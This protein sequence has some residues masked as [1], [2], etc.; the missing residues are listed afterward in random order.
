[1]KFCKNCGEEIRP[2]A[3]VCT[4]C[5]HKVEVAAE[6]VEPVRQPEPREPMDPVKK[7][8]LII[9]AA[10]LTMVAIIIVIVYNLIAGALSPDNKLDTIAEAVTEEDA[11][12][13][14]KSVD[15]D[16]TLEEA[17]AYI[18]YVDEVSGLSKYKSWVG[19]VKTA[20]GDDAPG[21]DIFDG[22]YTLLSVNKDGSQYW[23]FDDYS[24]T[25]PRTNIYI[26]ESY[27]MDKF[28]YTMDET[29]K[30]WTSGS[31]K[32]DELIPGKYQFD[33][34]AEFDDIETKFPSSINID[35]QNSESA[36]LDP[37][38]YYLTINESVTSMYYEDV[39]KDGLTVTVGGEEVEVNTNDSSDRLGPYQF[40]EELDVS[41]TVTHA[42]ETFESTN[43]PLNL[44]YDEVGMD[45]STGEA[46]PVH[47]IELEFDTDAIYEAGEAERNA[48]QLEE[49]REAFEDDME[50]N[51]ESFLSDYLYALETMYMFEDIDHIEDYVNDETEAY[52]ALES[53]IN[54]GTFEGMYITDVKYSDFSRDGSIIT[55]NVESERDYDLLDEP[56]EIVTQYMLKYDSE[57]LDFEITGFQ[58]I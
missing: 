20:L 7:K 10:G 26:S 31:D 22:I 21:S 37:G 45:Y 12:G 43:E 47:L 24:F 50:D 11:E 32:F 3:K 36:V 5:G 38:Y 27:D 39:S 56:A 53:N 19:D 35:F 49:E 58:D 42:G 33:G 2:D 13:L 34:T 28:V 23:L 29:E 17:Q 40:E 48:A 9:F 41:A 14:K 52:A 51:V 1:M 4:H 30:T 25:I 54:A 15:N 18:T 46:A 16:I 44:S 55:I 57:E 8:L 6:K